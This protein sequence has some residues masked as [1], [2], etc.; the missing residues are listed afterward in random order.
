M[1]RIATVTKLKPEEAIQKAI[2]YF[3]PDGHKLKVSNQTDT[4]AFF[5]G[6]GGSVAVT[7]YIEKC[8]TNVDLIS[9]EWDFQ[10]KEFIQLIR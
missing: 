9:R 6:G 7:A 4:S 3:G 10:V 2:K 1:L 8:E 5:E